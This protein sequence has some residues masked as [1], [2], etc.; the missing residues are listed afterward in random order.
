MAKFKLSDIEDAF[1]FVGSAAYGMNSA[2]LC[3]DTG[4]IY[5]RSDMSG[6]DEIED[7]ED[8]DWDQCIAVP[9]KNDLDLGTELVFEFVEERLPDEYDRVSRIFHRSGAYSRYKDLLERRGLLQ[10]WYDFENR[11]VQQAL[12]EWCEEE[13]IDLDE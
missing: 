3:K 10:E 13:E 11:R 2:I 4:E 8:L 9:Y 1:L 12:R 5:Y 7:E 6:M